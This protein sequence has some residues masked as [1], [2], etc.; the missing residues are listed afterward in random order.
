MAFINHKYIV[1]LAL[2][3]GYARNTML[4]QGQYGLFNQLI[5]ISI[6]DPFAS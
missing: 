6:F 5:K 1:T 4:M 3:K 2:Y